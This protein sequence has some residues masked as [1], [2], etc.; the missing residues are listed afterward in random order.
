MCWARDFSEGIPLT[1]A[2]LHVFNF[3][4][5]DKRGFFS[6]ICHSS[7]R[8]LALCPVK[9]RKWCCLSLMLW[10]AT[11]KVRMCVCAFAQSCLHLHRWCTITPEVCRQTFFFFMNEFNFFLYDVNPLLENYILLFNIISA[12]KWS[13]IQIFVCLFSFFF[14]FF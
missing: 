14:L 2:F 3:F 9:S 13:V 7:G 1:V 5:W 8:R 11:Q 4:L 12:L 6:P 10:Y